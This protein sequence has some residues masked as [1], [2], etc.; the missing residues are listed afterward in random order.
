MT[1]KYSLGIVDSQNDCGAALMHNGKII[2]A[3][4]EERLIRQKFVGG[5]PKES[6]KAIFQ[7]TNIN[8]SDIS[9][10]VVGGIL[11]PPVFARMFR[12]LQKIEYQVR[13]KR[14]NNFKTFLTDLAQ[15]RLKVHV[16]APNSLLG[17]MLMPLVKPVFRKDIPKRLKK[18][19]LFF[20]DHHLAHAAAAYYTQEKEKVLAITADG[21]GDGLSLT[22][23]ICSPKGIKKIYTVEAVNS[24]GWFY[25]LV[26]L[27]LGFQWHKHEGKVTGLAAYG[28]PGNVKEKF[29]FKLK[30]QKIIYSKHWGEKGLRYLKKI[31]KKY[32]R[33]DIAAWV[34]HH[35]E[36][37]IMRIADYWVKKTGI[38]DV[39]L[40]GGL[41]ANVKLNQ[42]IHELD[43]VES[44]YV[45]PHMGD[46]GLAV[47]SLLYHI[48]P[49]PARLDGAFFGPEYDDAEILAELKREALSY[50]KP[51]HLETEVA[52]LLAKGKVVAWFD[53]RMEFGP[54]ALG[55]RSILYQTTDPKVNDWLNNKLNRTE[56]MPFC[57]VTLSSQADKC[58]KNIEGS[59]YTAKFMNMTFDCTEYMKK[60]SPG[61]VHVDGTA[62]P[63]LI[64]QKDNPKYYNTLKEYYKLTG[65][66]SLINTS[67]NMHEE[68]IVCTPR[69]A[70]RA[71]K[72]SKL[73]C[74][75]IGSFIASL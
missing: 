67:L 27:S 75:V 56:F 47:G 1:Q 10:I 64:I 44:V 34:Q 45:F 25:G 8:P 52:K 5:F 16:V 61:V 2:F 11:T 72:Q 20:I 38:K 18:K 41:F 49:K 43:S 54:R 31:M 19:P 22:I 46:G 73:D 33:E 62:R 68:P 51:D 28:N 55:H 66:P 60:V 14:V 48:R 6:I 36:Q 15:F 30:K 3:V 13:K 32:S 29:P 53:G 26:T 42:R 17:Q 58:Y 70:I 71:F 24:Y 23:N 39:V 69:D 7:F 59:K 35:T 37:H 63:Q 21:C 9:E 57:P 40:C 50:R 12:S 4:N 74:L 65:I